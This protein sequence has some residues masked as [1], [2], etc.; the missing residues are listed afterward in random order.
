MTITRYNCTSV[1]VDWVLN[2]VNNDP[3]TNFNLFWQ[4]TSRNTW[5]SQSESSTRRTAVIGGLTSGL[6]YT[7]AIQ[8]NI[9]N[10]I[11]NT[12]EFDVSKQFTLSMLSLTI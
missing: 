10:I 9:Q 4:I 7:F 8:A 11:K 12:Y 2:N 6:T 3:V 1:T 5:F